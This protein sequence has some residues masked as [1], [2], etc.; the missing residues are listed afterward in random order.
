VSPVSYQVE[1]TERELQPAAVVRGHV[2]QSEITDFLGAAYGEVM[3]VVAEQGQ[4]PAG[5]PFGRYQPRD[6]GFDVAA[7]FPVTGPIAP[8]GRV[9]PDSLPGGAE[10]SVLHRGDYAAV[11]AAYGALSSWLAANGRVAT[12]APWESYLDEPGVD[13]PRTVV[14]VPCAPA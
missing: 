8:Q 10:A 2:A 1:L 3:R 14:R 5:P 12:G 9:E 13:Q 6:G 11:G 7:G 4:A